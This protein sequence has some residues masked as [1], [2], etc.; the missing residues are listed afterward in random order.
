MAIESY[1]DVLRLKK[2]TNDIT[3][4]AREI[5]EAN[6]DFIF[7]HKSVVALKPDNIY[8][9]SMIS[10]I[11]DYYAVITTQLQVDDYTKAKIVANIMIP[12][13]QMHKG[14]GLTTDDAVF[15]E[16]PLDDEYYDDKPQDSEEP[17]G[18]A[19]MDNLIKQCYEWL[20]G[21]YCLEPIKIR[22]TIKRALGVWMSE[23]EQNA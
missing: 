23:A 20:W 2:N 1:A 21:E 4:I 18:N 15:A 9:D 14:N 16:L 10:A 8:R 13:Y 5:R 19:L 17:M 12:F 3:G 22:A 6:P 11:V 7:A